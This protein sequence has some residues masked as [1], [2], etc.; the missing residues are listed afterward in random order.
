[1]EFDKNKQFHNTKALQSY[2]LHERE[3]LMDEYEGQVLVSLPRSW[4]SNHLHEFNLK[5]KLGRV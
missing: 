2:F 5:E 1:M 4:T 3:I